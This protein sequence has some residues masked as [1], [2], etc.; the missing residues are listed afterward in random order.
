MSALA[1]GLVLALAA[2][3]ALNAAFVVQHAGLVNAPEVSFRRP[4]AALRGLLA[5]RLWMGG[6][7]LGL[8]GWGLHVAALTDAPLSLVQAFVAGGLALTVP[9]ARRWLREPVSRREGV[10]VAVMALALMALA[11]GASGGAGGGRYSSGALW[12]WSAGG[13]VLA[14]LAALAPAGE[15]RPEALGLAGGILYGVADSAIKALTGA[16]SLTSPWLAL[17]ALA[18]AGAFFCFQGGLQ[19]GR[20]VP[21]IALMTAGTYVVS[22]L[23]G[24]VVFQDSLGHGLAGGLVHGLAF[25]AVVVA[26]WVLAPAQTGL[27]ASARRRLGRR[28]MLAA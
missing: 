18:T 12:A 6:L 20:A 3:L 21:V 4:L 2:S 23:A 26:A 25:A 1:V 22:I 11:A 24:V 7:A 16:W 17:A 14:A 5:S 15:R 13:F 10:A 27:A 28:S 8:G 19:L 9:A